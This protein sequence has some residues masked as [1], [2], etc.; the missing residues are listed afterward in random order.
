MKDYQK[1]DEEVQLMKTQHE[2]RDRNKKIVD[3]DAHIK[4]LA[5]DTMTEMR[6]NEESKKG[7]ESLVKSMF[8]GD[9]FEEYYK[10]QLRLDAQKPP[11]PINPEDFKGRKPWDRPVGA[12]FKPREERVLDLKEDHALY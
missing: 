12:P 10:K 7:F 11:R 9:N 4:E 5:F 8:V 3:E 2:Q 6:N 1:F